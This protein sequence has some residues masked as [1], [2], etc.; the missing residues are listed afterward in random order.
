MALLTSGLLV[1]LSAAAADS[2]LAGKY[3]TVASDAE[4]CTLDIDSAGAFRQ[5]CGAHAPVAGTVSALGNAFSL[6][7]R[8]LNILKDDEGAAYA[9]ARATY[10]QLH[11]EEHGY[12]P[13]VVPPASQAE[14]NHVG[15]VMVQVALL[16][17]VYLVDLFQRDA[18]CAAASSAKA[19]SVASP[20]HRVFVRRAVKKERFTLSWQEFCAAGWK[21]R[22]E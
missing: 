14:P 1:A 22:L 13:V 9:S 8:V 5:R 12:Y 6:Q 20:P 21:I 3:R 17:H 19:M 15:C 16:D 7:S 18:F 2:P 10:M 11:F 4:P